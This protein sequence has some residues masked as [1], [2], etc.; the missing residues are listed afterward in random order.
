MSEKFTLEQNR[1]YW[2]D[3]E[4]ISIVD[5]NVHQLEI[6]FVSKYLKPN[7]VIAD[8]GCGKG[9]ATLKYAEKVKHCLGIERSDYSRSEAEKNLRQTKLDNVSFVAGDILDMSEYEN[10]F[11]LAI[12]GRCLINL[13]SWQYQ[14]NAIEN[15]HRSLKKGGLYI[16]VENTHD[17]H[18]AMNAYR[19]QLGLDPIAI[20]WHAEFLHVDV[21]EEFIEG[22]FKLIESTGFNLY[23]LLTRVYVQ[24]FASFTGF[25]KNAKADPIF[26]KADEAARVLH[27]KIGH[28]IKFEENPVFGPIQGFALEKI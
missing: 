1:D 22:K 14:A 2:N 16:L 11:D 24:M 26:E 17:G 18:D 19:E 23:Y 9:L 20:H 8:I 6:D 15:V 13:P 27:E 10:R 25:G 28:K 21:F 12:T 3:P 7:Q 5:K 4:T